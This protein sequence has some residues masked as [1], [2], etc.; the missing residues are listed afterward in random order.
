MSANSISCDPQLVA[1]GDA[2][3]VRFTVRTST[4]G[5]FTVT[6]VALTA[7]ID[8]ESANNSASATLAVTAAGGGPTTPPPPPPPP[9]SGASSG[10]GGGGSFPVALLLFLA[11]ALAARA[12]QPMTTSRSLAS[13]ARPGRTSTSAT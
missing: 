2:R 3:T 1:D 11:L 8:P 13:T 7:A 10:G 9:T 6:A 12:A 4:A 5:N